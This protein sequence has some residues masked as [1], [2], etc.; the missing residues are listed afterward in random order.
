[1][2][3]HEQMHVLQRANPE[4]FAKFYADTWGFVH[5]D[6]IAAD[7]WLTEHQMLDS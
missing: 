1:M 5:A 6:S 4:L 2:L 7:P 3:L